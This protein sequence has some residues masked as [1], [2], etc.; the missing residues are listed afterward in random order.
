MGESSPE[1]VSSVASMAGQA[2]CDGASMADPWQSMADATPSPCKPIR[3]DG[4]PGW[5]LPS[6]VLPKGGS[7][8]VMVSDPTGASKRVERSRITEVAA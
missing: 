5:F 2:S 3:V 4:K 1:S 8:G 6:G 7:H